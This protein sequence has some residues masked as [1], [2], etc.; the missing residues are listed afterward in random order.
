MDDIRT[1]LYIVMSLFTIGA[2]VGSAYAFL[3][4]RLAVMQTEIDNLKDQH[5][6]YKEDLKTL[7]KSVQEMQTTTST[8]LGRIDERTQTIER[9]VE[10]R[11]A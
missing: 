9:I 11:D 4:T 10:R 5:D 1:I 3:R 8:A 2:S 7:V 6:E